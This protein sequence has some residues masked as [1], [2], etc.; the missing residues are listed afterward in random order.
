MMQ[1]LREWKFDEIEDKS[2]S[3]KNQF[4]ISTHNSKMYQLCMMKKLG[5]DKWAAEEAVKIWD[6]YRT[7]PFDFDN[8][9][10]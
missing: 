4:P 10:Y 8:I 7:K 6:T 2:S 5:F 3:T 1:L 9:L